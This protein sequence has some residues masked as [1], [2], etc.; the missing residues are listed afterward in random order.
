M[1]R[2]VLGLMAYGLAASAQ[3]QSVEAGDMCKKAIA[4]ILDPKTTPERMDWAVKAAD[5]LCTKQNEECYNI[6][7]T[8]RKF[9]Q[10]P[11]VQSEGA[12]ELMKRACEL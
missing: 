11:S 8:M 10:D 4:T 9:P 1:L 6:R 7:A 3:A 2:I 12:K 5:A